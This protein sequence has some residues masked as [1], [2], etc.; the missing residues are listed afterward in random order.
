MLLH[1][2]CPLFQ[3][4]RDSFAVG[5]GMIILCAGAFGSF[6]AKRTD[7][8][9]KRNNTRQ[10]HK[11]KQLPFKKICHSCGIPLRTLF[12]HHPRNIW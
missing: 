4:G 2:S 8:N 9:D 1:F 7:K 12:N 10:Q 5:R 3:G 6:G 11:E